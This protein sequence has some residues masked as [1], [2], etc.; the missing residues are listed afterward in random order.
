MGS[1]NNI[2]KKRKK[3]KEDPIADMLE[4]RNNPRYGIGEEKIS[5]DEA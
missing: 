3:Q 5:L 4:I 1:S 2:V